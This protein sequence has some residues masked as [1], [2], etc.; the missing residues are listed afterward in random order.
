MKKEIRFISPRYQEKFRIPDGGKVELTYRDGRKEEFT[1]KYIDDYHFVL[2]SS[3][4]HICEFAE[5]LERCG[6]TCK[7]AKKDEEPSFEQRKINTINEMCYLLGYE[8]GMGW[9]EKEFVTFDE[10]MKKVES[11][12]TEYI[13]EDYVEETE[14]PISIDDFLDG[15]LVNDGLKRV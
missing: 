8:M 13:Q 14:I 2:G 3:V 4:Y 9:L 12:A 11:W 5:Q 10:F 7:K 6:V 15:K 1:C